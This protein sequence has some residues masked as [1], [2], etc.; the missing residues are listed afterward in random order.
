MFKELTVHAK[1][2]AKD[3]GISANINKHWQKHQQ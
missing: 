1:T 2:L 3:K